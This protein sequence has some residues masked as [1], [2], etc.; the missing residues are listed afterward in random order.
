M[1]NFPSYKSYRNFFLLVGVA[2]LNAVI[3][4]ACGSW[5][6]SPSISEKE[7]INI[8]YSKVQEMCDKGTNLINRPKSDY[9]AEISDDEDAEVWIVHPYKK[10]EKKDAAEGDETNESRN[11]RL[12]V[13]AVS[14]SKD[15][16]Y[17]QYVYGLALPHPSTMGSFSDLFSVECGI[18][19]AARFGK[20]ISEGYEKN[21]LQGQE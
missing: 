8:T 9:T 3:F 21:R 7:A 15:H 14:M 12:N 6:N 20:Y 4:G 13:F 16:Y 2:L 18:D 10:P 5:F 1:S 17:F 11:Y 19:G